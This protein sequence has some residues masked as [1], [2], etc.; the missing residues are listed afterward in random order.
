VAD[1]I[2]GHLES[3]NLQYPKVSAEDEVKFEMLAKQLQEQ[4]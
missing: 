4:E 1:I 3:L 2:A